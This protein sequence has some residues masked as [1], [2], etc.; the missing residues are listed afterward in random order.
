M[1]VARR[2]PHRDGKIGILNLRTGQETELMPPHTIAS[3][4]CRFAA[5]QSTGMKKPAPKGGL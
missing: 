2:G 4:S 3:A 1:F 5:L